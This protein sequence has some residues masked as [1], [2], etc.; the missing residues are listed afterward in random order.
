MRI[1][2][3]VSACENIR[4]KSISMI[5]E[6]SGQTR[7]LFLVFRS[8]VYMLHSDFN[9]LAIFFFFSAPYSS[10]QYAECCV[11]LMNYKKST[12]ES[13][14]EREDGMKKM[15]MKKTNRKCCFYA[16]L[17]QTRKL[18]HIFTCWRMLSVYC[19]MFFA[20]RQRYAIFTFDSPLI[21]YFS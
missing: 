11:Y 8:L 21:S 14:I 16:I 9:E 15:T 17:L 18:T 3:D 13:F 7:C 1:K 5:R 19:V 4:K 6:L 12:A 2:C 20:N 10:L